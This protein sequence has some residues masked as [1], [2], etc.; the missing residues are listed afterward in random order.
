MQ[1]DAVR[2]HKPRQPLIGVLE[3]SIPVVK[4]AVR[5]KA[6]FVS[7][8]DPQVSEEDIISSL[9]NQVKLSSIDCTKLKTKFSS[10]SSFHSYVLMCCDTATTKRY[11]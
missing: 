6:L 3:C 10:Y 2:T 7:R 8:F 1:N 9:R 11:I 5:R 4:R